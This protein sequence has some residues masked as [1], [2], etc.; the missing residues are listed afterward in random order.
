MIVTCP[1]D[2]CAMKGTRDVLASYRSWLE[3]AATDL[4]SLSQPEPEERV[5]HPTL[6]IIASMLRLR[7][8]CRLLEHSLGTLRLIGL[9]SC[10]DHERLRT[11]AQDLQWLL[12]VPVH[13]PGMLAR[14]CAAMALDRICEAQRQEEDCAPVHETSAAAVI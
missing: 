8:E 14:Q 9:L 2:D 11:V 3:H 4:A 10:A 5:G 1:S 6:A 12:D 7:R 13:A